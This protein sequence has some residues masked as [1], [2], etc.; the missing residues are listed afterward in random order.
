MNFTFPAPQPNVTDA[1]QYASLTL[2]RT[3][4]TKSYTQAA[5]RVASERLKGG[6]EGCV[7]R[8]EHAD[9]DTAS[10]GGF[11]FGGEAL[12]TSRSRSVTSQRAAV[13]SQGPNGTW[14]SASV[15]SS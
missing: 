1:R 5:F 14:L 12:V 2:S 6:K 13:T 8:T 9:S 15:S 10:L 7:G 3:I 4:K 11:L